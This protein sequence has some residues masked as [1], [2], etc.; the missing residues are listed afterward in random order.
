MGVRCVCVT[1]YV[2]GAGEVDVDQLTVVK[3]QPQDLT[4]KPEVVQMIRVH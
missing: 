2:E 4:R 1:G 3:S